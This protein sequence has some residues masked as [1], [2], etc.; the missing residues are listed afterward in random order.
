MILPLQERVQRRSNPLWPMSQTV[1]GRNQMFHGKCYCSLHRV[2]R[3]VAEKPSQSSTCVAGCC[4]DKGNAFLRVMRQGCWGQLLFLPFWFHLHNEICIKKPN[5]VP[6][7]D[8]PASP[9]PLL[10]AGVSRSNWTRSFLSFCQGKE[11][12]QHLDA[13]SSRSPYWGGMSPCSPLSNLLSRTN[14][15]SHAKS[16]VGLLTKTEGLAFSGPQ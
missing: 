5:R 13:T 15:V 10:A 3:V 16:G 2:K 1:M 9:S 8:N 11:S 6:S 4:Q 14:G 12:L 7:K